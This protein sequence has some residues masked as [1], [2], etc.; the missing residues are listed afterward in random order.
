MPGHLASLP[1]SRA[2]QRR[3]PG[4]QA[5]VDNKSTLTLMKNHVHHDRSKHV[6]VM[7]HFFQEYCDT[8]RY[9]CKFVGIELQL[10]DILTKGARLRQFLGAPSQD[11]H[12]EFSESALGLRRRLYDNS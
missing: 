6:D 5:H 4:A 9:Q 7:F 12:E 11:R 8:D 10:G 3:N 1:A 2:D